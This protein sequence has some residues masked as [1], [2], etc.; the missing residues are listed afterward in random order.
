M[1]RRSI[2]LTTVRFSSAF[3]TSSSTFATVFSLAFSTTNLVAFT[4][5]LSNETLISSVEPFSTTLATNVSFRDAVFTIASN[6]LASSLL[7]D[8]S[9]AMSFTASFLTFSNFSISLTLFSSLTAFSVSV[10]NSV[11]L[12]VSSLSAA[13]FSVV[14]FSFSDS[15]V[16]LLIASSFSLTSFSNWALAAS[17]L[18]NVYLVVSESFLSCNT[19]FLFSAWIF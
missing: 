4:A 2:V 12:A 18:V 7:K 5:V 19:I 6:C 9:L 16:A 8:L 14:N 13:V 11:T 10:F 17:N 1:K 15:E 3:L